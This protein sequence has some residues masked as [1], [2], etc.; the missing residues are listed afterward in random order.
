MPGTGRSQLNLVNESELDAAA[1]QQFAE[2]K[3]Q[4]VSNDAAMNACLKRVGKRIVA[5]ARKVDG[6]LPPYE[7]WEFIVIQDGAANAFAMPGGKVAFNTGIFP[8]MSSD[9]D[10]AV[11]MGHEVSHVICRHGNERVSQELLVQGGAAVTGS[12]SN[13]YVKNEAYRAAIMTGYGVTAQYGAI[14]PYS[15]SHESE[16][17]LLGLSLSSRAGYD[18]RGA[19]HF[20]EK[21]SAGGAQPYEFLSTHPSGAT[22]IKDLNKAMPAA[23]ADYL[24]AREAGA[25]AGEKLNFPSVKTK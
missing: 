2:I 4:K 7:Q 8:L 13:K 22:R 20:W 17:D 11:V 25:S 21:M 12:L 3:K 10:V 18:P 9:D 15:R 19:V 5:E 24:K 1:A 14:L 16:A 6:S 23:V